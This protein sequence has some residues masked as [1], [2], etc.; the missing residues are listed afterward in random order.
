M[1][2]LLEADQLLPLLQGKGETDGDKLWAAFQ[3]QQI[4]FAP[5][6]KF[7]PGTDFYDT[8]KKQRIPSWKK[9]SG[10]KARAYGSIPSMSLSDHKPVFA[11]FEVVV[12]LDQWDGP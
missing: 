2:K 1:S 4:E 9:D 3:E 8:S 5:T 7:D 10:V 11:Q 12:D 6:Y